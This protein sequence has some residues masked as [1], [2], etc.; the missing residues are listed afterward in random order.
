MVAVEVVKAVVPK[1]VAMV[2]ATAVTSVRAVTMLVMTA[3]SIVAT[4]MAEATVAC[5]PEVAT[6]PVLLRQQQ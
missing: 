3:A 2:V 6:V 5:A 1:A 4:G